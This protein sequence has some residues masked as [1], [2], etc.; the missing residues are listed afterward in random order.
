MLRVIKNVDHKTGHIYSQK[1]QFI[2][3]ILTEEGY[4]VPSHK[5]GF[6]SFDEIPLPSAMTYPE[7]GRMCDLARRMISTTNMLGY[8][9]GGQILAYSAESIIEV[10]QLSPRRGRQFIDKMIALG[11]MQKIIRKYGEVEN[12]EFYINPAYFFAGK[13]ISFNLYLLFREHLDPILP[14]WV[15]ADFLMAAREIDDPAIAEQRKKFME[16]AGV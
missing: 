9:K 4:R 16:H 15:R 2:E 6:K 1:A 5:S 7:K 8:R 13:R 11:V 10:V 3:D 12:E 14:S